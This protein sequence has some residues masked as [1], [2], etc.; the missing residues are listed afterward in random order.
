VQTSETTK[1]PTLVVNEPLITKL[2]QK[3]DDQI[4][5]IWQKKLHNKNLEKKK[6]QCWMYMQ[7]FVWINKRSKMVVQSFQCLE[8]IN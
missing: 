6:T 2:T 4:A 7:N 8:V 3:C 1:G 5:L